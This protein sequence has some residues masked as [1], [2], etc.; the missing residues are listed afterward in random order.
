M[1]S[2]SGG[3]PAVRPRPQRA[4]VASLVG[5]LLC[6][7][8]VSTAA[9]APQ[10]AALGTVRGSLVVWGD[11]VVD[12][13]A[14][15]TDEQAATNPFLDLRL[16]V[17]FRHPVSGMQ[18]V[19]P[20]YYAADGLSADTG[21]SSGGVWRAHLLP[22][23]AGKWT[24][25]AI[26][27][28]GP[29]I[30][31]SLDLAAGT[32]TAFNGA[33]GSFTIAPMPTNA[34]GFHKDGLLVWDG[35]RYLRFAGSGRPFVKTG[36]NS[37]ENLLAF[38]DFDGTTP[39]HAYAAHVADWTAGDPTWAGGKGKGLVG[40]LNYLASRG[41]NSA[42][43][44]TFNVGGDGKDVW[45][46]TSSSERLRFDVSKLEQWNRVFEHM[47]HRGIM[48]HVV[49]QE[50]EN[51]TGPLALDGGALDTQRKLYYR[52]LVA[53]FAHHP[54]LQWNLGEENTN[55]SAQLLAFK[56]RIQALDPYDH[57]IV[58]HTFPTA[59]TG[60]Y[61]PLIAAGA[62][63]GASLQILDVQ[64]S[65]AETAT[66]LSA[67]QAGGKRW[68]VT[69]DEIGPPNAGVMPDVNDPSHDNVRRQALW[70]NLMAGGAGCEWYF[71]YA[72]PNDD[73]DCEDFRARAAM[74]D[75]SRIAREFFEQQLPLPDLQPADALASAVAVTGG[76]TTAW[77]L[78]QPGENYAIYLPLGGSPSLDVGSAPSSFEVRWL[79]PLH[80]GALQLGSIGTVRGPG[81]VTLGDPPH[82]TGR[83]WAAVVRRIEVANAPPKIVGVTVLPTPLHGGETFHITVTVSDPDGAADITSVQIH[84]AAPGPVYLGALPATAQA[85]GQYLLSIPDMPKLP[86]GQWIVVPVVFDS[87]GQST[88]ALK[89]FGAL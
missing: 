39:T 67:S 34:A 28:A 82:D 10:S 73:V 65:H 46:W 3:S 44:L 72:F 41:V 33:S 23:V 25:K 81:V 13:V 75:Q 70:G 83:D 42:Y 30:A 17:T 63:E 22:N 47:D 62:L 38:K 2:L 31:T 45:P 54:A 57:P 85:N 20:G 86:A 49:T 69:V 5:A 15:S 35:G 19:V 87:A 53:R 59:K 26:F 84:F 58:V 14:A 76:P 37:P 80:G 11:A 18:F 21:A 29:G 88:F 6:A 51:D 4:F 32:P 48:L 89:A 56:D 27:R 64:T 24:Y 77:C 7:L 8:S 71:G 68:A 40:A 36:T 78:A 43:F 50:T 66:W 55:T 61:M 1:S 16:D 12:F 74:W 60:V 52:E 9:L 79:D